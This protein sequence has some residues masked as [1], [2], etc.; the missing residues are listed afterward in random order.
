MILEK[1]RNQ[2]AKQLEAVSTDPYIRALAIRRAG[3]IYAVTP[4]LCPKGHHSIIEI[5]WPDIAVKMEL[6]VKKKDFEAT[7][8][9]TY[10]MELG[11]IGWDN[12]WY[13]QQEFE[14]L[15]DDHARRRGWPGRG[16]K[17]KFS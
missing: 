9:S 6:A 7:R 4:D 1:L 17:I 16:A 12:K 5:H 11:Y 3:Q 15:T 13:A 10:G 14:K 8:L 2:L